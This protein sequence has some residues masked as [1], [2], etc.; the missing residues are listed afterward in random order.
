VDWFVAT[1]GYFEALRASVLAGRGF[2]ESDAA[3]SAPVAIIDDVVA[4]RFFPDADPLGHVLQFRGAQRT[5]V[6]VV[7]QPR[8]YNV[9]SD[10]RGQVF[11]PHSQL[12][13]SG[14]SVVMRSAHEPAALMTM[15]RDVV[16]DIDPDQPIADVRTMDQIAADALGGERLSL[17]LIGGFALSALLLA[18]LG[19][20]GV[21]SN[22]V[23]SRAQEIGVRMALGADA[24]RVRRMVVWQGMRLTLAGLAIGLAGAFAGV[25]LLEGLLIGVEPIDPPTLIA[26]SLTLAAVTLLAAYVPA[27]R[28]AAV[29]P[30]AALGGE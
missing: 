12:A 13:A 27:R 10:D 29:D 3:D 17:L 8:L 16:R 5:V 26:V 4:R 14:M 2:A 18:T 25:R 1:P 19:L 28:A 11:L 6:G 7:D 30:M 23:T 24:R 20:Y 9:H 21:V 22:T 15:V